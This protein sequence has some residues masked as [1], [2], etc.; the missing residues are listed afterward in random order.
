MSVCVCIH[1]HNLQD[2]LIIFTFSHLYPLL[3]SLFLPLKIFMTIPYFFKNPCQICMM[4]KTTLHFS[5]MFW[6]RL[7]KWGF[8][9]SILYIFHSLFNSLNL[10]Y[11]TIFLFKVILLRSA[12]TLCFTNPGSPSYSL[13]YFTS[14]P[15]I[16]AA[17]AVL[18]LGPIPAVALAFLSFA[19]LFPRALGM[20]SRV[21][22]FLPLNNCVTSL[23]LFPSSQKREMIIT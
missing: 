15:L 19:C 22:L 6:W 5:L 23:T 7:I 9:L 17:L 8:K 21:R 13:S 10:P 4:P 3:S 20:D 18:S 16:S 12:M 14:V 2:C 11:Y 1:T